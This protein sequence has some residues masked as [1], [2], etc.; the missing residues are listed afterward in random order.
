VAGKHGGAFSF[1]G[2]NSAEVGN[3]APLRLSGAMSISAWLR[4]SSFAGSGRLI[5]KSG[6]PAGDVGWELWSDSAQSRL[7]FTVAQ[8]PLTS[9]TVGATVPLG[10]WIHVV[11]TFVPGGNL[12][13]YVDGGLVNAL[14]GPAN[15]FDTDAGVRLGN[16]PDGCCAF[17][18]LVDDLRVFDRALSPAEVVELAR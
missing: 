9:F 10:Q 18:G 15:G 17:L 3:V 7:S 13:L 2:M 11:A 4:I 16:R 6:E 1:N 12:S 5:S 14:P 8:S